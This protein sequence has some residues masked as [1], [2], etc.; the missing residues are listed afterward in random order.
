[1]EGAYRVGNNT[2]QQPLYTALSSLR[3]VTCIFN[4][5]WYFAYPLNA[6]LSRI[7]A[8]R[9]AL[10]KGK[11]ITEYY[12]VRDLEMLSAAKRSCLGIWSAFRQSS[13][14]RMAANGDLAK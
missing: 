12:S 14:R 2:P 6:S 7:R 13:H 9:F 3:I 4:L 1:M 11:Q 10:T 5:T 8:K